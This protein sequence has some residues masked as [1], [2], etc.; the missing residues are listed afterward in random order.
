MRLVE[1]LPL[2]LD[3]ESAVGVL[4]ELIEIASVNPAYDPASLG[5]NALADAVGALCQMMGMRVEYQE[6]VEGRRNLIATLGP[7]VPHSRLVIEVH[8]DTVGLPADQTAPR[9]VVDDDRVHG[10]G[11]CDVKGGLAAALL[12]L[13]AL[14]GGG[15]LARTEVTLLLAVDEEY[16]FRGITH[17]L[18]HN[19]PPDLAVVLEPT[20]MRVVNRHN[21]VLRVEIVVH[22]QAAHTSRPDR[23]RNAIFDA[24]VVIERL[25]DF[26]H[27]VKPYPSESAPLLSIS[28]IEG[29]DAIN[30]VPDECRLGVEIRTRPEDIPAE[31]LDALRMSLEHLGAEGVTATIDR[32]TLADGGMSTSPGSPLVRAARAAVRSLGRDDRPVTVPFG[33]DGS[34]LSRVAVDTVVIGPGSIEQAHADDEWVDVDEVV[35][36]ALVLSRLISY[37]DSEESS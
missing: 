27:P 14:T 16:A 13:S 36:T 10:R 7:T 34:K 1:L 4:T 6:V 3:R 32:V 37:I 11:A 23:G 30:I 12:A 25:R 20:E 5:E 2:A 26:V 15:A 19:E 28:T 31:V 24:L 9:A 33:T 18:D 22:G 21:G 17:Y 35:D 29:G 8:G